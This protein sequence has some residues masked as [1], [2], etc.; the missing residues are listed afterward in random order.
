MDPALGD[1]E[2]LVARFDFRERGEEI[3]AAPQDA[4]PANRHLVGS[5]EMV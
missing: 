3:M 1:N 4:S 5:R 2:T